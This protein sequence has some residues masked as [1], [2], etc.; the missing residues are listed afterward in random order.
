MP[1]RVVV[2]VLARVDPTQALQ[3]YFATL[4]TGTT[5]VGWQFSVMHLASEYPFHKVE[6]TNMSARSVAELVR[7]ALAHAD[8]L[9]VFA[10]RLS[11]GATKAVR[12]AQSMG[13][14][15]VLYRLGRDR[16]RREP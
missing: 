12:V 13:K 9:V 11:G 3:R 14:R 6:V 10:G 8:E 5:V 1:P 2:V 15:A 7:R 16:E 4:P